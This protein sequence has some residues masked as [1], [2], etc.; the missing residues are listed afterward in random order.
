MY[1]PAKI[2]LPLHVYSFRLNSWPLGFANLRTNIWLLYPVL[3]RKICFFWKLFIHVKVYLNPLYQY[4]RAWMRNITPSTGTS[5]NYYLTMLPLRAWSRWHVLSWWRHQMKTFSALL[6][7]CAGNSPVPGE[8]P[9]QRPLRRSFD[10][11]FEM[12]LDKRLCK[13]S[14]GWWFDTLS[15]R[16]WRHSIVRRG[17]VP[18]EYKN[19]IMHV[20]HASS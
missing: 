13:Q 3:S 5:E 16:L 7:L 1:H 9:A 14:R 11:F 15:R 8:F 20:N 4:V 6:D 12:R 2:Y 10:V 17:D 19:L 18:W